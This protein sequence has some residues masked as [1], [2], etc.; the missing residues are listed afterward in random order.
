MVVFSFYSGFEVISACLCWTAMCPETLGLASVHLS[1][2]LAT[3]L[4]V[5]S[6]KAI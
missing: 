5:H 6:R 3:G 4:I 2:R 1:D